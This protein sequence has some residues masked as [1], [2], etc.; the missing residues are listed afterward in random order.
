MAN[1]KLFIFAHPD[2]VSFALG[3][4]ISKYTERKFED[5]DD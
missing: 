5:M 4:I 1:E 2:D 3:G